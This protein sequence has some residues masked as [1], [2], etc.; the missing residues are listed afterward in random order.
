MTQ[1]KP[2]LINKE[3]SWLSFNAR[4]LYEAS[5]PSVPLMERIK[6]LGIYSSNLDEFFR[7]RVATLNRLAQLGKK[8]KKILEH[9][10]KKVIKDIQASVLLLHDKFDQVYKGILKDLANENIFIID[11]SQ[12]DE[13]QGKFVKSYFQQDVLPKLIPIM[14]DQ[15][16]TFP[17]LKDR[18]LYLMIFLSR[19][20]H[21]QKPRTALIRVPTDILS[22][23]L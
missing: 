3:M 5:D 13:K 1:N 6:F 4:V 10:P 7:V 11:E 12:L 22:R 21:P 16:E 18:A 9:N 23:F 20:K 15:I 14:I 2:K 19:D 8:T 17:V